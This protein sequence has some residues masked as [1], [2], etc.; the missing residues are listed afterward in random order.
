MTQIKSGVK[1]SIMLNFSSKIRFSMFIKTC[2]YC[3]TEK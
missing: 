3:Y 2:A 1:L